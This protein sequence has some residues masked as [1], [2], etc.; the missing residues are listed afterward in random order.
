MHGPTAKERVFMED[1][2][3]DLTAFVHGEDG[4][5]FGTKTIDEFKIATPEGEI[6]IQKDERWA[7]LLK[8]ADVFAG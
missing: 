3:K 5:V 4:H 6:E 2:I 8:L 1:W 7:H